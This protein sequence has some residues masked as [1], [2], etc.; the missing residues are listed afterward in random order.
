M[1]Q[2]NQSLTTEVIV[3]AIGINKFHQ[4][5]EDLEL[6]KKFD[7]LIWNLSELSKSLHP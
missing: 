3:V 7:A 1:Y 5:I 6:L 4:M 2:D